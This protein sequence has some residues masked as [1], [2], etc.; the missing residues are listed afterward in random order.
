MYETGRQSG[1]G[2]GGVG[3]EGRGRSSANSGRE[4]AGVLHH[5]FLKGE[6]RW[7]RSLPRTDFRTSL[8]SLYSRNVVRLMPVNAK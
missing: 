6:V 8:L 5:R 1:L 4:Q 7:Q 2:G 3:S